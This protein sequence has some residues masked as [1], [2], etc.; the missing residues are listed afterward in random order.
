MFRCWTNIYY[1]TVLWDKH[2]WAASPIPRTKQSIAELLR[3]VYISETKAQSVTIWL[4]SCFEIFW[5]QN[6]FLI[7]LSFS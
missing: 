4:L 7:F 2:A 5:D 3:Q 1:N 6:P